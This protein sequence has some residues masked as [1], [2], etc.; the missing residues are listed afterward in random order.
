MKFVIASPRRH[1]VWHG[2]LISLAMHATLLVFLVTVSRHLT[3]QAVDRDQRRIVVQ[4]LPS[5]GSSSHPDDGRSHGRPGFSH[6]GSLVAPKIHSSDRMTEIS[7]AIRPLIALPRLAP[8]RLVATDAVSK[9]GLPAAVSPRG[10]SSTHWSTKADGALTYRRGTGFYATL[11]EEE[12]R[13]ALRYP[14][15]A[16]DRGQ[17]GTAFVKVRLNDSGHIEKVT[18]I[19]SSGSKILD[20][21]ARAVFRQINPLPPFHMG[22]HVGNKNINFL[23]PVT[24][25]LD[26]VG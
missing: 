2:V 20:S 11:L 12:V 22:G 19:R 23:I 14:R 9:K 7:V 21:E 24:F 16:K 17:Q 5:F 15:I 18:L 1:L 26:N 10:S 6:L 13:K 4:L 25:R 8:G 3:H